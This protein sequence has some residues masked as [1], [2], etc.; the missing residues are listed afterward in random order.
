MVGGLAPD[1]REIVETRRECAYQAVMRTL[2]CLL[3]ASAAQAA[4]CPPPALPA[5]AE[6][7]RGFDEERNRQVLEQIADGTLPELDPRPVSH[8]AAT[9]WTRRWQLECALEAGRAVSADAILRDIAA[10]AASLAGR[11]PGT[12]PR[13]Q[14]DWHPAP[15]P[16]LARS[17]PKPRDYYTFGGVA[18][19]GGT[20]V[21]AASL[22]L[23]IDAARWQPPPPCGAGD[24]LC[25]NQLD[26][27]LHNVEIGFA[28]GLGIL[29]GAAT[30]IGAVL[31]QRGVHYSRERAALHDGAQRVQPTANGVRITF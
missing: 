30:I 19:A 25:L 2:L 23:A 18:L 13:L 3:F 20:L 16:P 5:V 1:V 11:A 6:G 28:V 7:E 21:L 4:T 12:L 27:D 22:A 8:Q 17:I 15:L 10:E 26:H 29:G 24:W 14:L 9:L 31:L